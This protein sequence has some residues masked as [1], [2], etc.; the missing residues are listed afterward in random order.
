MSVAVGATVDGVDV[1]RW[2]WHA[3][4]APERLRTDPRRGGDGGRPA[5]R[6]WAWFT[7]SR[8]ATW[9][10][11]QRHGPGPLR[12]GPLPGHTLSGCEQTVLVARLLSRGDPAAVD[13]ASA[14]VAAALEEIG[15]ADA[16]EGYE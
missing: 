10:L 16:R 1:A 14:G 3:A 13:G 2:A 8:L 11:Y 6:W 4:A 9:E 7:V 5:L 12:V 15:A